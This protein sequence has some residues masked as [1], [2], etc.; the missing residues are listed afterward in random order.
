M[1]VRTRRK[2]LKTAIG[3]ALGIAARG[4][5]MADR[6]TA[7]PVIESKFIDND[8]TPDGDLGKRMWS[9]QQPVWFDQAAF[10]DA[11]Y[12]DFKTRVASCWSAHF[13]Y[14]AFWCPFQTLTVYKGE[15]ATVERDRLWERDV[16]EAFIAPDL[17]KPSHYYEFEIAP[18]NQW[19]DIDIDLNRRPLNDPHWSS[20]FE[21]ATRVDAVKRVWT[22][23]MRIPIHSMGVEAIRSGVDWRV[24]FYRCDGP[25]DDTVRRMMSWG[26]LPVR[27]SGGTFHQPASFGILR[28]VG[29]P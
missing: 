9:A 2:F 25:G 20:G 23:E 4:Q 19:M 18:N 12:P 5:S 13:L 27:V 11:R 14:L 15:D 10:S 3:A 17:E 21:H 8:S 26:R 6:N 28:F 29:K 1:V 7:P 22:A 24:N 16:V